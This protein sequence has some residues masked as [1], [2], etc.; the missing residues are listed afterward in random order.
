MY[1]LDFCY[2]FQFNVR[3]S[4]YICFISF[5]Y[6]DLHFLGDDA[7]ISKG[8]FYANQTSMCYDPHLNK[9]RGW[10]LENGLSL[11]PSLSFQGKAVIVLWIICVI[12][13]LCWSCFRVCPLL[14]CGHL[15]EK[16]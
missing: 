8:F 5:L 7:R 4:P 14:P 11:P 1:L 10:R 15:L 9:W 12:S 16:G 3:L 13:V 6:L 2:G